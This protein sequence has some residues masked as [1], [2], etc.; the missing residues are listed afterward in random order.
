MSYW[1]KFLIVLL[2]T[3]SLPV[4]SLAA[5]SIKCVAEHA[6]G[7]ET[8][9][10]HDDHAVSESHDELHA[11]GLTENDHFHDHGVSHNAHCCSTCAS[12][13]ETAL[14]AVALVAATLGVTRV[15]THIPPSAG[16]VSFLT[17]GIERPPRY[18]L[19]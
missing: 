15:L 10:Q 3:L 2:L 9:V 14:P 1:G 16:T 11:G 6:G 4:R 8:P 5:V 7:V 18:T 17:G 12:C 13:F 19:L